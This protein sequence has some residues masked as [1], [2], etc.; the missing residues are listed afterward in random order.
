MV[1]NGRKIRGDGKGLSSNENDK[2]EEEWILLMRGFVS[3]VAH[4]V[5]T[6]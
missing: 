6:H 3:L 1:K 4:A 5:K 2:K